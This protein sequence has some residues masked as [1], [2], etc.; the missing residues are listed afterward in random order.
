ME[1]LR[2]RASEPSRSSLVQ[3]RYVSGPKHGMHVRSLLSRALLAAPGAID[4][5]AL[6]VAV[7]HIL[8]ENNIEYF[9]AP[10]HP[11]AQVLHHCMHASCSLE[12]GK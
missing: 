2:Q 12:R 8:C 1:P 3:K 9:V 4:F 5:R 10:Y 11:S 6:A 7:Q